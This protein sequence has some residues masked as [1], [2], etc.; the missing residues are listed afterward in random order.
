MAPLTYFLWRKNDALPLADVVV[1]VRD[2]ILKEGGEGPAAYF[3]E[4]FYQLGEIAQYDMVIDLAMPWFINYYVSWYEAS[5]LKGF[6]AMWITYEGFIQD[7]VGALQSIL[8]FHN[9]QRSELE[10]QTAM[11]SASKGYRLS[12][13]NRGV[14]GR[15]QEMLSANHINKLNQYTHYYPWV[16]FSPLGLQKDRSS[17]NTQPKSVP[18]AI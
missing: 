5:V 17:D 10:I 18:I 2:H 6:P 1:S 11:E 13:F 14:A 9:I 15:G 12:R 4:H 16:D 7:R 8:E 3:N